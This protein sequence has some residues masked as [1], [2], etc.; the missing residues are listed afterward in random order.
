MLTLLARSL[1]FAQM[2][3]MEATEHAG[4]RFEF[5]VAP[6]AA[7]LPSA[8]L[9]EGPIIRRSDAIAFLQH[10]IG[11]PLVPEEPPALLQH[12]ID[13]P[14][15]SEA[16]LGDAAAGEPVPQHEAGGSA[17]A[18]PTAAASP[19]DA[20]REETVRLEGDRRITKFYLC[21]SAAATEARCVCCTC[22][23]WFDNPHS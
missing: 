17:D 4:R 2:L 7:V 20:W 6:A 13:A 9:V 5:I 10:C 18:G 16:P 1:C 19:Y 3:A 11:A 22:L 8:P 21:D 23:L 12:G 15:A 14:L